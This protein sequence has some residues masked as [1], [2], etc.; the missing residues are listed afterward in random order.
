[1]VKTSSKDRARRY[2]Q[3]A[4]SKQA[5]Q[6]SSS[7]A[8]KA[9]TPP[10]G[11][12]RF[13]IKEEGDYI[14]NVVAFISGDDK[15]ITKSRRSADKGYPVPCVLYYAHTNVGPQK[16]AW[17]CNSANW[18]QP[19]PI[20]EYKQRLDDEDNLDKDTAIALSPSKRHLWLVE[21]VKNAPGKL[22][23]FDYSNFGFGQ[24]LFAKTTRRPEY[25]AFADPDEG[26]TLRIGAKKHPKM[27]NF[28]ECSDIE[29][30]ERKPI[31][32][33]L[34]QQV[35]NLEECIEK[36][37]YHELK[38]LAL[39]GS[40][41]VEDRDD[42]EPERNGKVRDHHENKED[43]KDKQTEPAFKLGDEVKHR[44][45]GL[46]TVVKVSGDGTSIRISDEDEDTFNV[47]PEDLT[48]VKKGGKDVEKESGKD[49]DDKDES[50]TRT[51]GKTSRDR[52]EEDEK[53]SRSRRSDPDDDDEDEDDD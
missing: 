16:E 51:S 34:F 14:L 22:K 52:N 30:T 13:F 53:P 11:M 44:N 1:M 21:D 5:A 46:C 17:G 26:F 4:T 29:F 8:S 27:T 3:I 49:K 42:D 10:K 9:F 28:F 33:E 50:R 15:V 43:D 37:D 19:C 31:S 38:S 24:Y 12:S 45:H 23:V 48:F 47:G 20:C 35:C 7:K 39:L 2:K 36:H 41:E 6:V 25:D 32:D 18:G 40:S